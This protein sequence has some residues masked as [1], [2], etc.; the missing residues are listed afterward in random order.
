VTQVLLS[1]FE[2]GIQP[3]R[4]QVQQVLSGTQNQ[5]FMQIAPPPPPPYPGPPPPY[6]GQQ[7]INVTH[8]II[9]NKFF[10]MKRDILTI[11]LNDDRSSFFYF[12]FL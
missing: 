10:N 3:S 9:Y 11:Q 7:V 2:G 6:P 12:N 5:A 8:V 4:T 1:I